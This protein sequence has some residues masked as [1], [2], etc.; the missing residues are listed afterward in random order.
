M[1]SEMMNSQQTHIDG[2]LVLICEGHKVLAK[3]N[4]GNQQLFIYLNLG[5]WR[6]VSQMVIA[7][8]ARE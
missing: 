8:N 3:G 7:Y 2:I 4:K 1:H 5:L 6:R